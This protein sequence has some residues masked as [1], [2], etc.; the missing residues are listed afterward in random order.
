MKNRLNPGRGNGVFYVGWLYT[1]D[2][3]IQLSTVHNQNLVPT[4]PQIDPSLQTQSPS[5]F[6]EIKSHKIKL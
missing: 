6:Q 5:R 1:V 2:N 4:N 3:S